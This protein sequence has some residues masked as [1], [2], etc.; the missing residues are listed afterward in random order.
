MAKKSTNQPDNQQYFIQL[1]KATSN[2]TSDKKKEKKNVDFP[3]SALNSETAISLT[4]INWSCAR[5]L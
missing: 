5:G 3:K 1:R 2:Q 4:L